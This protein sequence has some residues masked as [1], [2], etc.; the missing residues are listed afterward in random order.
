MT[1]QERKELSVFIQ[2][3]LGNHIVG[4]KREQFSHGGLARPEDV[5]Q[6]VHFARQLAVDGDVFPGPRIP[7]SAEY[8]RLIPKML[9]RMGDQA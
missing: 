9:L 4:K 5:Q 1:A 8:L 2:Q 7:D 3:M 6:R